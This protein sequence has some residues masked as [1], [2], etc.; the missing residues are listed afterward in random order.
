MS[1]PPPPPKAVPQS[2]AASPFDPNIVRTLYDASKLSSDDIEA[3]VTADVT[4]VSN[5]ENS[6][7]N[8][9]QSQCVDESVQAFAT[10]RPTPNNHSVQPTTVTTDNAMGNTM[11]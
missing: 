11:V 1:A 2:R 8:A 6:D 5:S 10:T 4:M 3:Y 7:N 9:T